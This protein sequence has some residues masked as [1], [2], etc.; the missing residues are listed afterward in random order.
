MVWVEGPDGSVARLRP[1]LQQRLL[2]AGLPLGLYVRSWDSTTVP[3][4]PFQL[5]RTSMQGGKYGSF[6]PEPDG[7]DSD[8]DGD[9]EG[10]PEGIFS[11]SE[12]EDEEAFGSCSNSEEAAEGSDDDG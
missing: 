3:P 8:G 2:A 9:S 1:W 6:D 4:P 12:V 5:N 11:D 7:S 10:V